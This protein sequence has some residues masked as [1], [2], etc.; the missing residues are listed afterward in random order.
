MNLFPL[1][2]GIFSGG[3]GAVLVGAVRARLDFGFTCNSFIGLLGG[4]VGGPALQ[5][6]TGAGGAATSELSNFLVSVTGGF[7]GGAAALVVAA[8]IRKAID[9]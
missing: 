5:Q 8:G 2:V 9:R 1:F 3:A 6:L 7:L 4:A